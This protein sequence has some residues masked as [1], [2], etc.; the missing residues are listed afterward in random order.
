MSYYSDR[1]FVSE[2]SENKIV[3][4]SEFPV[5]AGETET[6]YF[7]ASEAVSSEN[8][9]DY[10]YKRGEKTEQNFSIIFQMDRKTTKT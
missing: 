2:I 6:S 5:I 4:Q 3:H 1:L 7:E 9:F 10:I 8:Y